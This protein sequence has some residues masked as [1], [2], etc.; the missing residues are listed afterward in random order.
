M[1]AAKDCRGPALEKGASGDR[2]LPPLSKRFRAIFK[3]LSSL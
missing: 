3:E 1:T 2:V